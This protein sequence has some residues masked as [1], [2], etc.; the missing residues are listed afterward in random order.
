MSIRLTLENVD[1]LANGGP[2]SFRA[3]ARA[4][5]IGR[6]GRDWNLPDPELFI[7]GRHCEIRYDNG[8]YWLHDV[9][10][11]GTFVNGASQRLG[12]PHHL[13]DGDR[14][15]IGRYVVT[16]AIEH[17]A[18]QERPLP[19]TRP[20]DPF[21]PNRSE[22]Q[23][24]SGRSLP[25]AY[26]PDPR[27]QARTPVEGEFLRA[28]AAG[29]GLN[30][31]TFANRDERELAREIG[32]VLRSV[33]EETTALLKAR[34]AAKMLAKSTQ[35]TMVGAADNN[36][37]KFLPSAEEILEAMFVRRRQGYL[38]AKGSF[39]DAFRDLKT[40][41]LATYSA[42]Q[43]A[44]GRILDDLS[45]EAI[46]KKVPA[47]VFGSKKTQAWEAFVTIW[48][49]RE[50]AHENG[51]LDVFLAYFSEAYAKAVKPK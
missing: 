30:P 38:D 42:M 20:S 5:E 49:T 6:E 41:E 2:T 10:R 40:H 45:P 29:A 15:K 17:D 18:P 11:N 1:R 36:P 47:S 12:A 35:R 24:T 25:S 51:M 4:F 31:E 46:E 27:S 39:E 43:T 14:L 13:N 28:L 16:V 37:L 26:G 7:S 9:S 48:Q 21:F 22:P 23:R 34:A 8:G 32:M 19:D 50:A 3:S 44:L 33:V